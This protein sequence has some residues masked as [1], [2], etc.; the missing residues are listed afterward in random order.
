MRQPVFGLRARACA[1]AAVVVGDGV[2]V[3]AC[4]A[5]AAAVL[6]CLCLCLSACYRPLVI[7]IARCGD[8]HT[9]N[10]DTMA[11]RCVN[12]GAIGMVLHMR[13]FGWGGSEKKPD[14]SHNNA[15]T[16]CTIIAVAALVVEHMFECGCSWIMYLG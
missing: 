6:F 12:L 1:H 13:S 9:H 8:T 3:Y 2:C 11:G 4:A 10:G 16:C 7:C 15:P 5:A 14:L